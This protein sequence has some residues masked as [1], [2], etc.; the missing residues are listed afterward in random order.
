MSSNVYGST[1]QLPSRRPKK[2]RA[3]TERGYYL[4]NLGNSPSDDVAPSLPP[5]G[6]SVWDEMLT[7]A[8]ANAKDPQVPEALYWIN[9][10]GRWGGSWNHSG[11]RAFELLHARYPASSWAKRSPY[12]YD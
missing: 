11:R 9:R 3:L 12:Y 4:R 2:A 1:V 8:R 10:A 5:G 6:V 7:Y